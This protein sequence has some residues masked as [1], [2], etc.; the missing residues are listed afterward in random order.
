[1]I[2]DNLDVHGTFIGPDKADSPLSIDPDAGCP[3]RSPTNA[4][5][6]FPGGD[7]KSRSSVAALSIVRLR[8]AADKKFA[9]RATR[10]PSNNALVSGQAKD[11]IIIVGSVAAYRANISLTDK[12]QT[13][14][15]NLAA[16]LLLI[17]A[18]QAGLSV[19]TLSRSV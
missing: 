15:E 7:L 5:N 11:R 6:L 3:A 10:F 8:S 2:V 14:D 13:K 16:G 4:S 18:T 12:R 1:V 19:V 17:S 9:N